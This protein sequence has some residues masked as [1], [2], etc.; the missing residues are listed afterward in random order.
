MQLTTIGLEIAQRAFKVHG[1]DAAGR[2]IERRRL[3]RSQVAGFFADLP[4]CFVGMEACAT[5]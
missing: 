2:V 3:Q 4:T 5:A 1:V